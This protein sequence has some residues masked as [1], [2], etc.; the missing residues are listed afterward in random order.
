VRRI[1][2]YNEALG[3]LRAGEKISWMVGGGNFT[4]Y[5]DWGETVR[6]DTLTKLYKQGLVT[7]WGFPQLYGEIEYVAP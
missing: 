6:I 7:K 2:G 5:F 4:A 3:R 1:I